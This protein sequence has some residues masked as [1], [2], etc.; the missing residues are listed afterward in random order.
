VTAGD[1]GW[2]FSGLFL[3]TLASLMLEVLDSRLLSVLTW[4]HLAFLSV[5][6]AMLG[7]SSGAIF[8]YLG[9]DRFQGERA[10]GA[11][12]GYGLGLALSIALSHIAILTIPVSTIKDLAPMEIA[13]LAVT[14]VFLTVPFFL[15]GIVVTIALTRVGSRIGMLYGFDMLGA[16]AGCLLVVA[17]MNQLDLSSSA[18]ATAAVA[19]GAACCFAKL[20][21]SR[22][23][24]A[25]SLALLI[26][27]AGGSL[28]N[29][30]T[31]PRVAV[32]FA[33]DK[34]L[35]AGWL[36]ASYWNTHSFVLARY[37]QRGGP[38]YWGAGKG[39]GGVIVEST[40]LL[41]DADAGT[42]MT[43]WDG[44]VGSLGWTQY[45]VTSLPYHLRRGDVAIIGVGGGRDV[46]TALWGG[47][48]SITGIEINGILVDLL[49]GQARSYAGIADRDDVRLVHDEARSYLSRT[50][51][52]FD[53][54]QMS[55]IDTWAATGAGA[56]ALSENGLYTLEAW[57][58]FLERL[59]PGGLL[60]VS[61][62]FAPDDVSETSRLL[63]L[64]VAAL[65][66]RGIEDPSSHLALLSVGS[67]ATL[68]VGPT[69][70]SSQ[71]VEKIRDLARRFEFEVRALPGFVSPDER[72]HAIASSRT[73]AQLE[74]ATADPNY[75]YSP[76]TDDRPYFFNI[77]KPGSFHRA[78]QI[79]GFGVAG[80]VVGNSRATSTLV[81]LFGIASVLVAVIILA[82]LALAGRPALPPVTFFWSIAYFSLI[83]FGFMLVQVPLLQR[84]AVYL[85]HPTYT[86]SVIL[87]SMILF[88][89]LGSLVSDRLRIER[90]RWHAGIPIGVA[91][92]LTALTVAL[93]PVFD[94][95]LSLELSERVIVTIGL[96]AP[97]SFLAGFCFPFG[98][99]MVSRV[100]EDATAWMWGIN[101]ACSV[102]ASILAVGI[103]LW[104]GIHTSLFL[105]AAL[106]LTLAGVAWRLEGDTRPGVGRERHERTEAPGDFGVAR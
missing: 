60:S 41:I 88:A 25:A 62:W 54:I 52:R 16:A 21:G 101:G 1:R 74:D 86:F 89:G 94:A 98:M 95:T 46:L 69:P 71:D 70:F 103:S 90:S 56:F 40:G 92:S 22:R 97:S 39:A 27:L 11:L 83:G 102:L 14:T 38:P 45:D 78:A 44:D 6:V 81:A 50:Q 72:I 32:R 75:D 93:Q 53:V 9:G 51:D 100:S 76:P 63:A 37:P 80:V 47:S 67:V 105:A 82:P 3:T 87:F 24:L 33:K 5:S 59:K 28:W 43:R 99:R 15:S 48:S 77:L 23:R 96:T 13:S 73:R 79:E 61:R 42:A 85:G 104:A 36:Q 106:Y 7:M 8:V 4:Y 65:L 84:F 29:A 17:L 49:E 26:V 64:A 30:S 10:R 58:V 91:A 12:T 57:K 34:F 55:L 20:A 68:I 66:E 35:H 31:E 19:A 18:F 2:L